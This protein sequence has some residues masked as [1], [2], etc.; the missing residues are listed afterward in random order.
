MS[1]CHYK[2]YVIYV[3]N[4]TP[5]T[6][7]Q[8][9]KKHLCHSAWMVSTSLSSRLLFHSSVSSNLLLIYLSLLPISVCILQLWLFFIFSNSFL[10]PSTH[11]F[12]S[13]S[14]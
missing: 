10:K 14:L 1:I 11:P 9:N 6:N 2:L 4:S 5:E 7:T 13:M 3:T 8:T 12:W